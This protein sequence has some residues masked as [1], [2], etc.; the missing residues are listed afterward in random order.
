[1]K[2]LLTFILGI[3][4]L[5]TIIWA[6]EIKADYVQENMILLD[7]NIADVYFYKKWGDAGKLANNRAIWAGKKTTDSKA[8][9]ENDIGYLEVWHKEDENE[10]IQEMCNIMK[11]NGYV[12]AVAFVS[13]ENT[14]S[15][16]GYEN[17][18][19]RYVFT[20]KNKKLRNSFMDFLGE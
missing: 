19:R 14:D 7:G 10:Y 8:A 16:S 4:L 1:M 3:F 13:F 9:S 6:Q 18:I 15:R 2:K 20:Y 12:Y 5:S 17:R 11:A